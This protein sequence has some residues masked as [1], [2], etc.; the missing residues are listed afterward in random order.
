MIRGSQ[1]LSSAVP[2]SLGFVVLW[3]LDIYFT[4]TKLHDDVMS[5]LCLD[6]AIVESYCKSRQKGRG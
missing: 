2:R 5:L 4:L 1:F 6:R 3:H